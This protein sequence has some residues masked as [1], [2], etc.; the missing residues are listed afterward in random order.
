[1]CG[2]TSAKPPVRLAAIAWLRGKRALY[3]GQSKRAWQ[4]WRTSSELAV[5][6]DMPY[7]ELLVA[8]ARMQLLNDPIA[9]A[10]AAE[11]QVRMRTGVP[12]EVLHLHVSDLPHSQ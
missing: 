7:D 6:L 1:M 8:C 12:L 4:Y 5:A 10:R 2:P 9:R 11:L 3:A